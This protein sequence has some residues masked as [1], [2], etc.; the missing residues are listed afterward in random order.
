[1]NQ[2]RKKTIENLF[3]MGFKLSCSRQPLARTFNVTLNDD[4]APKLP[5][6]ITSVKSRLQPLV[7]PFK[8]SSFVFLVVTDDLLLR[9]DFRDPEPEIIDLS[10]QGGVVSTL[11]ESKI[12]C[13]S[14]DKVH[15]TFTLSRLW[16]NNL[17]RPRMCICITS[18]CD[19][20][21]ALWCSSR[22]LMGSDASCR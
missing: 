13:L 1:L 14:A 7:I 22:R 11:K 10:P 15:K 4:L 16:Q 21:D 5:G 19:T 18:F 8:M 20:P 9:L 17:I 12:E 3:G 2:T 6:S